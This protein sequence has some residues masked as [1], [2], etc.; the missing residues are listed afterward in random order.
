MMT[1]SAGGGLHSTWQTKCRVEAANTVLRV[2]R[3]P[4]V[5]TVLDQNKDRHKNRKGEKSKG[6]RQGKGEGGL[7]VR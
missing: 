3:V 6:G 1:W 5:Q 7:Y 4:W 2:R